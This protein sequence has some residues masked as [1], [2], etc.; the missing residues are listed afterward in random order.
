MDVSGPLT[1]TVL[2]GNV[3]Y[4]A[5]QEIEWDAQRMRVTNVPDAN[6]FVHRENREGWTL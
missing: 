6:R 4:R 2:L 5:G 1:E 3:A